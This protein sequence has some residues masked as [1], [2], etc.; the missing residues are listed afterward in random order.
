MHLIE[1]RGRATQRHACEIIH[2]DATLGGAEANRDKVSLLESS[3]KRTVQLGRI[4]AAGLTA[5]E[6]LQRE[7]LINLDHLLHD[8]VMGLVDGRE[9]RLI[10]LGILAVVLEDVDDIFLPGVGRLI[11]RQIVPNASRSCSTSISSSALTSG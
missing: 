7:V 1:A 3:L 10:A 2:A 4:E 11:G 6:I 9:L 5:L 8:S